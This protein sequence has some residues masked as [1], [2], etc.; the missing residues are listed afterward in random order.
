MGRPRAREAC[1][2]CRRLKQKCDEGRPCKQCK[3]RNLQC[4]KKYLLDSSTELSHTDRQTSPN[5]ASSYTYFFYR[6]RQRD[7]NLEGFGY[8]FGDGNLIVEH[9][10]VLPVLRKAMSMVTKGQHQRIWHRDL[11]IEILLSDERQS[12]KLI[13][14][15]DG[16]VCITA[17]FFGEAPGQ[18]VR[19]LLWK[20]ADGTTR[21]LGPAT[22][23]GST[24]WCIVTNYNNLIG[25]AVI[26]TRRQGEEVVSVPVSPGPYKLPFLESSQSRFHESPSPSKS[27]SSSVPVS[28]TVGSP[29]S[30]SNALLYTYQTSKKNIPLQ[31]IM[32]SHGS[33]IYTSGASFILRNALFSI[34][35]SQE[36][37][38]MEWGCTLLSVKPLK[39]RLCTEIYDGKK[40]LHLQANFSKDIS[41]RSVSINAYRAGPDSFSPIYVPQGKEGCQCSIVIDAPT[42]S[43][44]IIVFEC[45]NEYIRSFPIKRR[46][47]IKCETELCYKLE[48]K[49][50]HED[51]YDSFSSYIPAYIKEELEWFEGP[52]GLENPYLTKRKKKIAEYVRRRKQFH[53]LR[54]RQTL[55]E[56][57]RG[58][59]YS[60]FYS[61]WQTECK[62][63]GEK[64]EVYYH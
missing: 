52:Y 27:T 42:Y 57:F 35:E 4:H 30:D 23:M 13:V 46:W 14:L 1:S 31:G 40:N 54:D 59:R 11:T 39:I 34:R 26:F 24:L 60:A 63:L 64:V 32:I 22:S 10:K 53:W 19:V 41:D 6:I 44:T 49:M 5:L 33:S 20:M 55:G 43:E 17:E 25:H 8:V 62:T 15:H 9:Y 56:E 28:S 51:I 45:D 50:Q 36:E 18:E 38:T 61:L 58:I 3:R 29:P 48:M 47:T 2:T 16:Q 21:E 12:A 7:S 37:Q